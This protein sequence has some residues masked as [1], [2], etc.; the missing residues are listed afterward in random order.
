MKV[1]ILYPEFEGL[2][3]KAL[4]PSILTGFDIL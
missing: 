3:H 2:S 4:G 1:L